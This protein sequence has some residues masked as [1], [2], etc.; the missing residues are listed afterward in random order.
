MPKGVKTCFRG[1]FICVLT[2]EMSAPQKG[3]K[4][5][6]FSPVEFT[7]DLSLGVKSENASTLQEQ[8]SA[9]RTEMK[10]WCWLNYFQKLD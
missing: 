1:S 7:A 6:G 10:R 4:V 8:N 5:F 2:A 3:L 9:E